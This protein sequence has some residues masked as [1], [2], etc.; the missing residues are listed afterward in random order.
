MK[1]FKGLASLV[2]IAILASC[3]EH[4]VIP[5]P[6]PEVDLTASFSGQL[7][8]SN[9]ELIQ[10]V[11]GYYCEATQAK[12]ILPTPQPSTVTYY[13]A[14]KSDSQMDFIQIGIGKLNFNADNSIDPSVEQFTSFFNSNTAPDYS[15]DAESG[16]EIVFRDGQGNVW[17]SMEG[18]GEP[19]DF[20]FTSLTQESDENGDYMKFVAQFNVSLF[21]DIQNPTDTIVFENAIF[22]GYFQ[23]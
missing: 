8:G 22:E 2:G 13:S 6:K 4:E 16:V 19:Q 21:D 5:P 11:N 9:Y 15:L 18:T 12:E 17:R 3:I 7:E 1:F 23:K 10:D 14:I 20:Q